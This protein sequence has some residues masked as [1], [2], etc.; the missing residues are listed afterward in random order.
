MKTAK[1]L[2]SR[3]CASSRVSLALGLPAGLTFD[4][5]HC[6]GADVYKDT[7]VRWAWEAKSGHGSGL[8]EA[9]Q[10]RNPR[11]TMTLM[12]EGEGG[13]RST[14][15]DCPEKR[16]ERR[17]A[18]VCLAKTEAKKHIKSHI[19]REEL[20]KLASEVCLTGEKKPNEDH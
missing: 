16:R 12:A 3:A 14:E 20:A 10:G 9:S 7:C 8:S 13:Q 15:E 6:P 1:N 2:A 18:F 4:L 19:S 11:L 5:R 17:G